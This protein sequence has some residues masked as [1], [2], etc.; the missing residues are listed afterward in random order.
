MSTAHTG[1]LTGLLGPLSQGWASLFS[2]VRRVFSP[3]ASRLPELPSC[4]VWSK[5]QPTAKV[6][7]GRL[8]SG[9]ASFTRFTC[10]HLPT[11]VTTVTA[12]PRRGRKAPKVTPP[13]DRGGASSP[14]R[15]VCHTLQGRPAAGGA[16]HPPSLL[17]QA[18]GC[19]AGGGGGGTGRGEEDLGP[20]VSMFVCL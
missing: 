3:T 12:R 6:A 16:L 15:R 17:G 18:R 2:A 7:A 5:E 9:C 20:R 13:G 1:P 4:S 14:S 19:F 11:C 10:G 8:S